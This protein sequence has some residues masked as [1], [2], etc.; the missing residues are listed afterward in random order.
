[1]IMTRRVIKEVQEGHRQAIM[2]VG[3]VVGIRLLDIVAV[4]DGK[5]EALLPSTDELHEKVVINGGSPSFAIAPC[6]VPDPRILQAIMSQGIF[7]IGEL[8]DFMHFVIDLVVWYG[9]LFAIVITFISY[10]ISI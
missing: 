5:E 2:M 9:V 1:V 6:V 3:V 7:D 8:W 10:I 4:A